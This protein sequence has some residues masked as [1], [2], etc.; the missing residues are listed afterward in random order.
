[1]PGGF[2][3]S[4]RKRR[5]DLKSGKA[6]FVYVEYLK[7]LTFPVEALSLVN[8]AI[9][10]CSGIILFSKASVFS[11][12]LPE[13]KQTCRFGNSTSHPDSL[14]FERCRLKLKQPKLVKTI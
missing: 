3:I 7:H 9:R 10:G 4:H 12:W 8:L 1:M 11:T 14:T 13:K 6:V 5:K 2:L